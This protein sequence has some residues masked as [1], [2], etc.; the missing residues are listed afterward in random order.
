MYTILCKQHVLQVR[1]SCKRRVV[2]KTQCH[3]GEAD[4]QEYHV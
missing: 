2:K 1:K 4:P 3:T